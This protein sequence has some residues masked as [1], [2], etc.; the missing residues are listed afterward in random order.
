M[1]FQQLAPEAKQ[2]WK[3]ARF[4][5]AAYGFSLGLEIYI[6][7]PLIY[8]KATALSTQ[9]TGMLITTVLIGLL[10]ILLVLLEIP[11]GALGDAMGRKK[12]IV[13]SFSGFAFY[14]L[15]LV[16]IPMAPSLP[17][18]VALGVLSQI[19][20]AF[21]YTFFSGSFT[22]WC[23]DSLREKAPS[24]SYE[25][26]LAR[27]YTY[28]Q[29]FTALGGAIGVFF[30]I[31]G[32]SFLP[33]FLAATACAACVFYCLGEMEDETSLRYLDL[34]Q[35]GLAPITKRMGEILGVGFE[36]FRK[37]KIIFTLVLIFAS[38]M[39]VLNVVDYFWP[40]YL[41]SKLSVE[42]QPYYWI[43]LVLILPLLG[44]I[45]SHFITFCSNRFH[46][47][48]KTREYNVL[49]RK[50]LVGICLL[51]AIPIVCLSY[52]THRGLDT[53]GM[54]I[55]TILPVQFG[56]GII[57]PCFETLVNN[58][59][60][61]SAAGERATILSFASLMKSLI[62]MLLIIPSGGSS[63]ATTTVSWIIPAGLLI[64]VTLIGN[65]V[66]KKAQASAPDIIE[67]RVIK[68][69]E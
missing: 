50:I 69:P 35:V 68:E 19:F 67:E 54:F 61:S 64:I 30:Y 65:R 29:V 66:L 37:S 58:Y 23:V 31:K 55:V 14:Y 28:F 36:I 16:F 1:K 34:K 47:K 63:G 44:A 17:V 22:A 43:G 9:Q 21:A 56:L 15:T 40:V 51:S 52:L 41:R 53:F 12:T 42:S 10:N 27:A 60:P 3:V 11:T 18:L 7:G 57:T 49:L 4:V 8:E 6:W 25:N 46:A 39:F 13:F 48:H 38:Y 45:G 24:V 20:Y 26:L 33:F 59:I 5:R 62:I 32:M 2:V